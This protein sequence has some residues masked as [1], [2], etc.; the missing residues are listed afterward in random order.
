MYQKQ[1][2]L[3]QKQGIL[4]SKWRIL[5]VHFPEDEG[6]VQIENIGVHVDHHGNIAF[7]SQ[8][9]MNLEFKTENFV[10]KNEE[11]CITNE[12]FLHFKWV[13]LQGVR[14]ESVLDR[15]RSN[16]SLDLLSRVMVDLQQDSSKLIDSLVAEHQRGLLDI[17]YYDDRENR[18]K[19]VC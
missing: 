13:I 2:I 17:A 11:L 19:Y 9:L 3:Y 5:Q 10:S 14:L 18:D 15:V 16:I 7:V 8:N 12:E 6:I 1:G 4:Y